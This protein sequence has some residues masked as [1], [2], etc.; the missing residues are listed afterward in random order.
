[1][2]QLDDDFT[3]FHLEDMMMDQDD[4]DEEKDTVIRIHYNSFME[5]IPNV[6]FQLIQSFSTE[7]DYLALMSCGK[8]TLR[9]VRFETAHFSLRGKKP[10]DF[11]KL[12]SIRERLQV[13]NECEQVSI[14]LRRVVSFPSEYPIL[15]TRVKKLKLEL[16]ETAVTFPEDFL[17]NFIQ[18]SELYLSSIVGITQILS[19]PDTVREFYIVNWK[20][21]QQIFSLNSTLL[22]FGMVEC[23][24]ILRIPRLDNISEVII[25]RCN[26]L[27]PQTS[28]GLKKLTWVDFNSVGLDVFRTFQQWNIQLL[29]H[30]QLRCEFPDLADLSFLDHVPSVQL[31]HSHVS[32]PVF[33]RLYFKNCQSLVLYNFNLF[34]WNPTATES[35]IFFPHCQSFSIKSCVNLVSLPVL[36]RCRTLV[37]YETESIVSVPVLPCLRNLELIYL[38]TI[39]PYLQ[40]I[41]RYYSEGKTGEDRNHLEKVYLENIGQLDKD[42]SPLQNARHIHFQTCRSI[43]SLVGLGGGKSSAPIKDDDNE[44]GEEEGDQEGGVRMIRPG[45]VVRGNEV[46][47]FTNCPNITN[48]NLA[49]LSDGLKYLILKGIRLKSL[50][51][52]GTHE[53]LKLIDCADLTTIAD[54]VRFKRLIIQFSEGGLL[55]QAKVNQLKKESKKLPSIKIRVSC[56]NNHPSE[57]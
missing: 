36:P 18:V 31:L 39:T 21:L 7:K 41:Q 25:R 27:V 33:L 56:A 24:R 1:M 20:D 6:L 51:R 10:A 29:Q 30:L 28:N 48:Y 32:P 15:F 35:P 2:E 19:I 38:P 49:E 11:A 16:A 26:F 44:E 9:Q 47:K 45:P 17:T 4:I 57:V 22:K 34:H 52:I 55:Q 40:A 5:S 50:K 43:P 8:K 23:H 46:I 13:Q 12:F 3:S 14:F 54:A 53:T 42:L 37:N